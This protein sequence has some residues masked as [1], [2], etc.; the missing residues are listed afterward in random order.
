MYRKLFGVRKSPKN[1]GAWY[2]SQHH[3]RECIEQLKG[4][5]PLSYAGRDASATPAAGYTKLHE[6]QR[7]SFLKQALEDKI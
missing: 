2:S 6:E 1:Q 4:Q 7:Q 3:I 5:L